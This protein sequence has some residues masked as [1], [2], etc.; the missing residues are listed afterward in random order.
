MDPRDAIA[1]TYQRL[2]TSVVEAHHVAAALLDL[3]PDERAFLSLVLC[4][5]EIASGGFYRLL[6]HRSGQAAIVAIEGAQ[7]F[8][9][10]RHARLLIEALAALWEQGERD[11]ASR[12]AELDGEWLALEPDLRHAL[13]GYAESRA[14]T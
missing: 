13:L 1:E 2:G 14:D 4:D 8:G 5:G 6:G 10:D 3:D 12:F 7:R 9:L 11:P